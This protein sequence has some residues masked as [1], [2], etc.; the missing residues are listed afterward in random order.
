MGDAIWLTMALPTWFFQTIRQPFGAGLLTMIPA[1]GIVC[2]VI[3]VLIGAIRRQPKLFAFM[4]SVFASQA[5]V[6]VAGFWRGQLNEPG[7]VLN[8]FMLLQ[9]L[10][11]IYL[12]YRLE[13][14]RLAAL[15]LGA[16]S[17]AYAFEAWFI[18]TMSF[19]DIWL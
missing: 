9:L 11:V 7:I 5:L 17:M 1:A 2:L 13:G 18:S 8:A 16:F 14:A 10:L 12:I 19:R 4:T 3:G 15:F 6:A